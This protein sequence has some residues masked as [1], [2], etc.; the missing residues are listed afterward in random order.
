MQEALLP[1]DRVQEARIFEITDDFYGSMYLKDRT[2]YW[3]VLFTCAAY[4]SVH[5]KV[6]TILAQIVS[7]WLSEDL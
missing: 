1:E 7:L 6:V 4:H 5:I 3:A 2:K